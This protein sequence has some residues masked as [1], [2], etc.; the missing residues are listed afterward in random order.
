[1]LSKVVFPNLGDEVHHSGWN[2]CSSCH[3]DPSKKRSHLVLPCLNSD[4]IYVVNVENERDLRLEMTIEPALLHDYNVSMPHTAHCTAAG[5]VIISTLGD[6]QGENKGYF[7]LV[8]TT[9]GFILHLT[10]EGL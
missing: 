6:A 1:V 9:N 10:I 3:S 7:L 5:D 4:R 2:T 8:T